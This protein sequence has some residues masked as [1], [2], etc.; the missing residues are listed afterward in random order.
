[1]LDTKRSKKRDNFLGYTTFTFTSKF[2]YR[3]KNELKAIFIVCGSDDKVEWNRTVEM[4]KEKVWKEKEWKPKPQTKFQ[5]K[6]RWII[7]MTKPQPWQA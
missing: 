7:F 4:L 3:V 1:M 2:H 5:F 6:L